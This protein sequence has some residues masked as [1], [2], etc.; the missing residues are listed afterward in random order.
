MVIDILCADKPKSPIKKPANTQAAKKPLAKEDPAP[1]KT[2]TSAE[3]IAEFFGEPQ[4][5][6]IKSTLRHDD[7][8]SVPYVDSGSEGG[9]RGEDEETCDCS[10]INLNSLLQMKMR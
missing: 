2:E 6:S 8:V 9:D 3:K 1:V 7:E 5:T 4:K 10:G